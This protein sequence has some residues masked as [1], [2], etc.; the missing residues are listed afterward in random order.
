MIIPPGWQPWVV[1]PNASNVK[2]TFEGWLFH[3][4]LELHQSHHSIVVPARL[5]REKDTPSSQYPDAACPPCKLSAPLDLKKA[6][7]FKRRNVLRTSGCCAAASFLRWDL[8]PFETLELSPRGTDEFDM[9]GDRHFSDPKADS[10]QMELD[11][12]GAP[13]STSFY[14]PEDI[15]SH[16][17]KE[18]TVVPVGPLATWRWILLETDFPDPYLSGRKPFYLE[19]SIIAAQ[20]N[21]AIRCA[22]C[23]PFSVQGRWDSADEWVGFLSPVRN[24]LTRNILLGIISVHFKKMKIYVIENN[25]AWMCIGLFHVTNIAKHLW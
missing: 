8:D 25:F 13:L 10:F 3:L 7:Y 18:T 5:K 21:I 14:R 19:L 16:T 4:I 11:A 1:D 17:H 2:A 15:S 9:S 12:E 22:Y 24:Y 23:S 20:C 6:Q